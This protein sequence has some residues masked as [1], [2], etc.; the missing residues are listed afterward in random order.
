MGINA[1]YLQKAA[2]HA[3]ASPRTDPRLECYSTNPRHTHSKDTLQYLSYA[4]I[5]YK[6]FHKCQSCFSAKTRG[7]MLWVIRVLPPPL[8]LLAT[9]RPPQHQPVYARDNGKSQLLN[10]WS[11]FPNKLKRSHDFDFVFFR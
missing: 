2:G 3:L 9:N 4:R 7:T 1:L 6:H 10:A 11:D 8:G 5:K